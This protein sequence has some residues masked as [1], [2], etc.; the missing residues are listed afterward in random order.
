MRSAGTSGS[1]LPVRRGAAAA[2]PA[3]GFA[4][5][6]RTSA[7]GSTHSG[8]T[9]RATRRRE[10]ASTTRLS[11]SRQVQ[12]RSACAKRSSQAASRRASPEI[13]GKRSNTPR[14]GRPVSSPLG[15]TGRTEVSGGRLEYPMAGLPRTKTT[16]V[17]DW[18]GVAAL[19]AATPLGQR[20]SARASGRGEC[21][22]HPRG[23]RG[24]D[25]FLPGADSSGGVEP[26]GTNP[27]RHGRHGIFLPACVG[28]RKYA[29]SRT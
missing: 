4:Q 9:S 1:P 13:S 11:R 12:A 21:R 26:S 6:R 3:M 18:A 23:P 29:Q 27:L 14:L 5:R 7:S 8:A 2:P 24:R 15:A 19:S 20:A 16:I 22:P 25:I 10:T 17:S 28:P